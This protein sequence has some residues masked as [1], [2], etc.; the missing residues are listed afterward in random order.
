MPTVDT[1][2]HFFVNYVIN[3]CGLEYEDV[4]QE[5]RLHA[6]RVTGK[7]DPGERNIKFVS[8]LWQF[9]AW[10]TQNLL[11]DWYRYQYRCH[12][13]A[14]LT[15]PPAQPTAVIPTSPAYLVDLMKRKIKDKRTIQII[16]L[17]RDP[18]KEIRG[19][20]D[21]SPTSRDD[22][23]NFDRVAMYL[24]ISDSYLRRSMAQIKKVLWEVLHDE[25]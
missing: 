7:F 17:L 5:L 20:L 16:D 4:E 10:K 25:Q 3:R 13:I 23:V 1:V 6:F 2:I 15:A 21:Q 19:P 22:D 12:R 8:Y 24:G 9:L 14:Y 11:R 18:P